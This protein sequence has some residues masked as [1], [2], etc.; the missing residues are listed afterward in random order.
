[1]L[2]SGKWF[3]SCFCILLTLQSSCDVVEEVMVQ[4]VSDNVT[5]ISRTSANRIS[6]L[7]NRND[8]EIV[9]DSMNADATI[10]GGFLFEIIDSEDAGESSDSNEMTG[11]SPVLL[12][13]RDSIYAV[14]MLYLNNAISAEKYAEMT[15]DILEQYS[16]SIAMQIAQTQLNV[17][18]SNN[19]NRPVKD[20]GLNTDVPEGE[21]EGSGEDEDEDEDY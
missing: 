15:E 7:T 19:I 3:R 9:C 5:A 13:M 6:F 12:A 11:R 10:S 8:T 14:C 1:M 4:G 20:Y 17:S 18:Q 16:A 21:A 2:S